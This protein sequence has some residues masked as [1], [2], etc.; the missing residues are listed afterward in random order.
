MAPSKADA[1]YG[2]PFRGQNL[3]REARERC[4]QASI[5]WNVLLKLATTHVEKFSAAK[6]NEVKNKSTGQYWRRLEV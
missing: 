1:R 2:L 4:C 5:V 6:T 3:R